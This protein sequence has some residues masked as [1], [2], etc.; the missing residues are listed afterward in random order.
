MLLFVA[1]FVYVGASEEEKATEISISLEGI[2]V[3]DI[4]SSP[5]EGVPPGM[6]LDELKELMFRDKHRGYP[7]MEEGKLQG[8]VTIADLQKTAPE[9]RAV[10]RVGEV[11]ARKL[12]LIGPEDEA[13][14]AMKT[15]N[16]LQIR[17][18]P[19]MD[20]GRLVGI[21]SRE[22]LVRAIELCRER[23]H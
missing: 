21:L 8:M 22:D 9:K 2:T 4:M 3:R 6:T 15:M 23:V 18:L 17:R 5:V 7:V 13:A 12:Y 19:V 11:M 16:E 14:V 20:G 10:T 1:F